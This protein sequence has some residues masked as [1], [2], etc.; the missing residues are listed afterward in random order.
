MVTRGL[1]SR[2][3]RTALLAALVTGL[4]VL[5]Q[6]LPAAASPA[7]R[8]G[9][10]TGDFSAWAVRTGG[11]GSATV[12]STVTRTDSFAAHLAGSASSESHAHIRADLGVDQTDVTV[13]A[14]MQL[15]EEGGK[16]GSVPLYRLFDPD[17]NRLI[18]LYRQNQNQNKLWIQHS[19]AF[20]STTGR[21]PLGTWVDLELRVV[22]TGPEAGTVVAK[23]NGKE[24][25]KLTK[26]TGALDGK[27]LAF[28][29]LGNDVRGQAFQLYADEVLVT[30]GADTV[31]PDTSIDSAP[32]LITGS[33]NASFTF[34]STEANSTFECSLDDVDFA[35]CSSPTAYSSLTDGQHTFRV[36][37]TDAAGNTDASSAN[38]TWT[39]DTTDNTPPETTIDA[40]PS[41]TVTAT[42]AL[43]SFSS[44]KA[45]STFECRLTTTQYEPC[46]SPATYT[47]LAPG[48]YTFEVRATDQLGNTDATPAT[49]SWSIE[50]S[51][52]GCD[53]NAPAPTNSDPGRVVVADN[54]E[55]G[56]F[57]HWSKVTVQGD[58][59]V[60]VQGD[61][62]VSGRCA[63]RVHVTT[64]VWDSR[65]NFNKTLPRG[66]GE[67]WAEG[68]FNIESPG[69][70]PGWNVPTFRFL[71]NGK[72][73]LDVSRQNSDGNFFLRTPKPGGGWSYASLG[74]LAT[75]R[76]YRI[77]VH[78]VA[79]ENLST[80]EVLLDGRKVY[81][82]DVATLGVTTVDVAQVGAEH[83]NQEGT[84]AAD[85]VIV[86]A[87]PAAV[88][89]DVFR[90]GFESGGF[91]GWT[92][93]TTG[94]DGT[95]QV[96]SA[97]T[98][99]GS[100]AAKLS[101]TANAGSVAYIR[102]TLAANE[103]DVSVAADLQVATEGA[104]GSTVPL[105]TLYDAGG[106]RVV[107]VFRHNQSS[108]RI[109]VE[110]SGATHAT[111]GTLPL[112][113]WTRL[114]VRTIT[115]GAGTTTV[116]VWMDGQ[117]IYRTTTGNIPATG[118]KTLQLGNTASARAF[119]LFADHVVV[120]E[121]TDGPGNDNRYKLLIADYLNKRLLITDFDGRVVWKM[122][123]PSGNSGYTAGPIGVRWQPN[124][125]ILAT[126]GT[127]EVGVID[128]ATKKWVWQTKGYNGE[129]FQSPYDAELLPDG[130]LAV[131]LRFNEKGRISVYDRTTG[132][133]VWKHLLSNAHA[134]HFRT[135]EQSYNSDEPTLLVGG[136]GSVREVAYRTNGGQN[137]TWQ[138]K[139][140]YTH[141]VIVVEND[142]LLTTEGYYIQKID[143][144]GNKLWKKSTPDEDRRI[145][146]NPNVGGGYIY[147]VAESDRVEFRD[148]NGNF[149]RDWSMLSDD[150]GLDYPYGIQVIE[151]PG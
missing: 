68:Q 122:D 111:T 27:R 102:K 52:S 4:A 123:N 143:R 126:F 50:A 40:G 110:H 142:H 26:S 45:G 18:N 56:D 16:G 127:G 128:V 88:T 48:E 87:I 124:N 25:Y 103:T 131:A 60:T 149:L 107:T 5:W 57:R 64:K 135:P 35:A 62:V 67:V 100:H 146:V 44:S 120:T 23:L 77:K 141:D 105:L 59:S 11:D 121:G 129:A 74:R 7:F 34:S 113:T 115:W 133:Q 150:T 6:P 119:T 93:V 112:G 144:L 58:A 136:W 114:Q 33:R 145:A 90:D 151:Y 19:G 41:G 17:G 61:N 134:V 37:A 140:E 51:T 3:P 95:A 29:Q 55:S 30:S 36:R 94:G 99:Q 15:A 97:V 137:V 81:G 12:Q 39:V 1:G 76:W 53:P 71:T 20:Y 138:V 38:H 108:D 2:R 98:T 54:F 63:G 24:I 147:T 116:E 14:Q 80:V 43:F 21:L 65:A 66:T 73:V 91:G 47:Q 13:S 79:N 28:L 106:V 118:V 85:D 117:S 83:Q 130:N 22:T 69:V 72:R 125:Q 78:I 46:T 70:D 104:R 92:S 109:G 96:Q 89:S 148:V 9:F 42:E 10:E 84:F 139:S 75:Q 101:A 31:P 49:R 132:E 8:D 86:K 32:A 82:S